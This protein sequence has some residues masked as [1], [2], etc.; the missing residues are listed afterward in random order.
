MQRLQSTAANNRVYKRFI[1]LIV[2]AIILFVFSLFAPYIVPNDPY[3]NNSDAIR[4]PPNF[5]YPFGTDSLGRC[6]FSRVIVGAKTSISSTL[7]LVSLTFSFGTIIGILCGYYGGVFDAIV[8]RIID[9]LL[10]VP[11]MVLAIAIAG[12]MGGGMIGAIVAL[13]FAN[14]II[15]ARIAKTKTI[16]L[17]NEDFIS[18]AR[19]GGNNDF[20]IIFK[21][22][23][24]NIS[25]LL[26]VNATIQ[27][28]N[29]LLGFAG[30]SFLGLGVQIP[31]AEWGSMV[32]ESRSYFQ[33]APWA[34]LAPGGAIV[35]T[36]M[37]FNYLGDTARDLLEEEK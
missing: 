35:F 7:F 27:I 25:G 19:L 28:A 23:L 36:T 14:W 15:Y 17:K 5:E 37:F 12:T 9:I 6:V 20:R 10:S 29:M 22:I 33:L 34:V 32:S 26:F 13:G 1:T 2:I 11:Q 3:F 16:Y 4:I 18:A 31:N 8:M 21:Y 24:P 30:L